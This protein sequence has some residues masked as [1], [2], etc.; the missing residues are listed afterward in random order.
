M[1]A[2]QQKTFVGIVLLII[3]GATACCGLTVAVGAFMGY[4]EAVKTAALGPSD[5]GSTTSPVDPDEGDDEKTPPEDTDE[6]A[7]KKQLVDELLAELKDQGRDDFSYKPDKNA[8]ESDSGAMISLDNLYAEYRVLD[9][10]ERAEFVARTARGVNPPEIPSDWPSA[11]KKLVSTVR[12]RVFVELLALRADEP[13]N[14]L[15]R[16]ASDDLVELVVFDGE[17]SMQYVNEDHLSDW[18]KNGDEVFL[19][20]RKN[21]A[22]R[23]Q[24]EWEE[25]SP[26]VWESPW[27]DNNDV[28]RA[29]LFPTLRKLGV[30][31][32]P[33]IFLPQ[34]DH[35]IV[36]GSADPEG[37][38]AAAGIV[39]E[40]LELPR[41]N[42]GRAW[43]LTKNGLVPYVPSK[44]EEVL[45]VLRQEADAKD[46][47]EQKKA[48]D[49]RFEKDG[50]DLFVG[51]TLFT[52]DD[53]GVQRTYA[54]WTKGADTLMPKADYI[55]FVD[56]DMPEADRV[57]AAA[58][59]DAVIKK[60][61][62]LVK[63]DDTYWP[64]RYRVT[65]YPTASQLKSL[66]T[67]PVFL[68]NKQP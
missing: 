44:S 14:V 11:R 54:V 8:L 68:R 1:D 15:Q 13:I 30:K 21:L 39:S 61:G 38:E 51:T 35:L 58:K 57:V 45:V 63:A 27:A 41:A 29:L 66:G 67:D 36:A 26:G 4:Q 33:V 40:R 16:P 49:E 20:A 6:A 2:Q 48:L 23:S 19:E 52:D 7:L 34:R 43:R 42:T 65:N 37:L 60:V 32:D 31:G 3:L 47:N 62:S 10:D 55:V 53:D 5:A 50:T 18:G 59:W 24:D 22:S 25:V 9:E 17:D 46:A 12:D 28:G 56:L 64:R